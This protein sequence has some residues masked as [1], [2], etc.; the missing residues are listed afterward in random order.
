MSLSDVS[1]LLCC[2]VCKSSAGEQVDVTRDGER[3]AC[4][5]GH[6]FPITRGI[7][8]LRLRQKAGVSAHNY[9][10]I[11][12]DFTFDMD[13][14]SVWVDRLDVSA[15]LVNG[16]GILVAGLGMGTELL[17]VDAFQPGF[18]VGL[19]YDDNIFRFLDL[20]TRNK[21][22][23]VYIQGDVLNLPFR[24]G[25]FDV[26]L[27]SGVMQ[28]LRS[29]ELGFRQIHHVT[30]WGGTI[31]IGSLYDQGLKNRN[32][33]IARLRHEFH[34][35]DYEEAKEKLLRMARVTN[36]LARF[37]LARIARLLW[38]DVLI[39]VQ[40]LPQVWDYYYPEYR[41]IISQEE[42]LA[43]FSDVGIDDVH[44]GQRQYVGKKTRRNAT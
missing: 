36:R 28:H 26:V 5:H 4:S 24:E 8:D 44:V 13:A 27:N 35:M 3:L 32:I 2:P 7:P 19:G 18:V 21:E 23:I 25:A 30:K 39:P 11:H 10:Q 40:K 22:R 17:C 6:T 29:P 14:A 34:K 16:N 15:E 37:R 9:A 42:V 43:W 41:H 38:G 1:K 12:S 31:S 33:T 20:E